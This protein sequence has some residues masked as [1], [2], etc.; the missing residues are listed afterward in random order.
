MEIQVRVYHRAVH[1]EFGRKMVEVVAE[2]SSRPLNRKHNEENHRD[3]A[4]HKIPLGE[5]EAGEFLEDMAPSNQ[6]VKKKKD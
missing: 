2:A 3:Q 4:S 6:Q 1:K 5:E